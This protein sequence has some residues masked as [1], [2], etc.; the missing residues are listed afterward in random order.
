M[1]WF[2]STEED[3]KSRHGGIDAPAE[4]TG[5]D[6]E[7]QE[8]KKRKET[9]KETTTRTP[10]GTHK[11]V[12]DTLAAPC[13]TSQP[14]PPRYLSAYLVYLFL[15][16]SRPFVF[17]FFFLFLDNYVAQHTCTQHQVICR[18]FHTNWL[19]YVPFVCSELCVLTI[20]ILLSRVVLSVEW[21]V[22]N[23]H[24][25]MNNAKIS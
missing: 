9:R 20:F 5:E 23:Q 6:I 21:L 15:H 7:K 24:A 25:R 17:P 13:R 22:P 4:E 19:I 3:T 1:I 18:R 14:P 16:F 2:S 11:N 10:S 8:E 12:R